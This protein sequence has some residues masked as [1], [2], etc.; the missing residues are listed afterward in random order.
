MEGLIK[1]QEEYINL[2]VEELNEVTG[3]ASVHGWKSSRVD[4]GAALRHRISYLTN[5]LNKQ[6][7][8]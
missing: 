7:I 5:Q 2:L 8:E 3:I 4:Q 6:A 1:A